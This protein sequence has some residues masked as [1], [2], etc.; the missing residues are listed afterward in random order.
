[1]LKKLHKKYHKGELTLRDYLAA[2]RTIL[3]NDRTWLG[4][5]RTALTLFVAGVTFIKF[6]D[7][8]ILFVVGW[9]FV[10]IGILVLCV[11]LWKYHHIRKMIHSIKHHDENIKDI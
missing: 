7:N 2:H 9:V 11:G 8:R 6:F 1:M 10:P 5:I 4:Y 3:A